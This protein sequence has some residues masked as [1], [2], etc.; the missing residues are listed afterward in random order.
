MNKL[1]LYRNVTCLLLACA[2]LMSGCANGNSVESIGSSTPIASTKN[3]T[4]T[5]KS[6][7]NLTE[8][9]NYLLTEVGN[10]PSM[11]TLTLKDKDA[12]EV[13]SETLYLNTD[14]IEDVYYQFSEFGTAEE[15][16]LIRVKERPDVDSI[17]ESLQKHMDDRINLFDTYDPEQAVIARNGLVLSKETYVGFI[18]CQQSE[19]ARAKFYEYINK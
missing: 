13:L 6:S 15:L 18:I 9:S 5:K 8:F 19:I 16:L 1:K 7:L 17:K 14:V 4:D 10:F 12:I 2:L 3:E 11:R